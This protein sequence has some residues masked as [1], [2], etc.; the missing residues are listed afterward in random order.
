MMALQGT[1]QSTKPCC[2]MAA[3]ADGSTVS[4]GTFIGPQPPGPRAAHRACFGSTVI[5][6]CPASA[7][8]PLRMTLGPSRRAPRR[9]MAVPLGYPKRG[10]RPPDP[11]A[12]ILGCPTSAIS[13]TRKTLGPS[14]R[15]PPRGTAG[16]LGYPGFG[17][18]PPSPGAGRRSTWGARVEDTI[19]RHRC[20]RAGSAST[21]GLD[22]NGGAFKATNGDA[23]HDG[24]AFP[25]GGHLPG[26]V[27]RYNVNVVL[28]VGHVE[29]HSHGGRCM[30][31]NACGKK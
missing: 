15:E 6:G 29:G 30:I 9:G 16:T 24:V 22:A 23:A 4:D 8:T 31:C 10:P 18:Q 13:A 2:N 28:V 3:S 19:T 17:P 21:D 5:L 27:M 11:P 12:V 14:R 26:T 1:Q 20:E 25:R 7:D